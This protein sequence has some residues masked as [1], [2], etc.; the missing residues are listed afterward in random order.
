MKIGF[1]AFILDMETRQLRR[2]QREIHLTP[3]AYDLLATLVSERPNV[4][5]KATLQER[6][7]PDAFVA[8]A[9]L[10]NLI[11]EIRNAINDNPRDPLFIRTAHGFG[12]AFCGD[13]NHVSE[14][15]HS[16][17]GG[18]PLVWLQWG[19]KRFPLAAG[20]H[21]IGRDP[22]AGISLDAPT[23]SRHHARLIV[24]SEATM[25]EDLGSKNGT[26]RGDQR[27]TAPVK[28]ADGDSLRIGSLLVTFRNRAQSMSTVT[29]TSSSQ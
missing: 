9:N 5:S 1:G 21:V 4:L 18:N 3:K 13:A 17:S 27:V 22:D 12:Y 28:L 6:I 15:V 29:A 10:S 19:K 20:T 2:G 16:A 8:E 24:S 25:F 26:F 23:V 11:A 14:G 7:W